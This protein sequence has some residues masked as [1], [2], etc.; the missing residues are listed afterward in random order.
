M[1][2]RVWR[3]G[4]AATVL[5]RMQVSTAL[6]KTVWKFL[7]KLTIE[8]SSDPA[9]RLLGMYLDKTIIKKSMHPYK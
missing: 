3:K 7:R 9:I 5:V 6:W 2:E 1:L 4:N 8:V